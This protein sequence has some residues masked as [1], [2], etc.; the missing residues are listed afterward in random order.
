MS[1]FPVAVMASADN[2][3]LLMKVCQRAVQ[4]MKKVSS[5]CHC[6]PQVDS[7]YTGVCHH[8]SQ[9]LV[10]LLGSGPCF[11]ASS[12]IGGRN[13]CS[14]FRTSAPGLASHRETE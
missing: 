1:V 13:G 9:Y 6:F 10:Q 2:D 8:N 4:W 12:T 7:V 14:V 3:A 5:F 11:A